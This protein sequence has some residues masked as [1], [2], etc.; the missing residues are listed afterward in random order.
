MNRLNHALNADHPGRESKRGDRIMNISIENIVI[1]IVIC[2]IEII[3]YA[4]E[5]V[6][7]FLKQNFNLISGV[8]I[9]LIYIII[10]MELILLIYIYL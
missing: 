1:A 3:N 5:K 8:F 2:V 10:A 6:A 7:N 4:T 9:T